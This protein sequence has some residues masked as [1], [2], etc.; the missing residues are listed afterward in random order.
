MFSRGGT[1]I[2]PRVF[3]SFALLATPGG[4]IVGLLSGSSAAPCQLGFR[5]GV[6]TSSKA[7]GSDYSFFHPSHNN[8]KTWIGLS[9]D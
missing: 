9:I 8:L 7:K 3:P 4:D 1:L 2:C 6:G 5:F